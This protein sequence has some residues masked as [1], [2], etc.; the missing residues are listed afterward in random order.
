M[1]N[2]DLNIQLFATNGDVSASTQI[3]FSNAILAKLTELKAAGL[4]SYAEKKTETG[5]EKAIF[6]RADESE[7][8]DGVAT[9]YG[10]DPNNAGDLINFEAPISQISSQQKIKDV[11]MKKTKLDLKTPFINSMGNAVLNKEDSKILTAIKA[12]EANLHKAGTTGEEID[13]MAQIRALIMAVRTAH[14]KAQLTPDGKK[15]VVV[16]MSLAAYTKLSA[17]EVFINGDYKDAFGG[18]TGDLPLTFYGA[19]IR[20]TSQ[21]PAATTGT[22]ENIYVIPSN[23]F[24]W[25]EWEGS[26]DVTAEFHK[27]DAMRWHLQIVKS[28]GPVVIEPESITQFSCKK[29]VA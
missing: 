18:G 4:K 19:E 6:Y 27:T 24:G 12:K 26:E 22:D 10:V 17:S 13:T 8:V 9:M 15:G 29:V 20:I 14:A 16:A 11:D 3:L 28:V 1:K 5:G 2:F 25:A 23:T 7:A 21:I